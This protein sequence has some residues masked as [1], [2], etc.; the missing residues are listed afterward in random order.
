M[1]ANAWEMLVRPLVADVVMSYAALVA[2]VLLAKAGS[3]VVRAVGTARHRGE[4]APRVVP[5]SR[6]SSATRPES[7]RTMRRRPAA[8][9]VHRTR[10]PRM[11]LV[12]RSS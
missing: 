10:A 5:L 6:V 1:G 11:H 9:L 7:S 2:V 12:V 3:M 8:V 4:P